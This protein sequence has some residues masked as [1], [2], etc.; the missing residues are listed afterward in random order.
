MGYSQEEV[1]LYAELLVEWFR[2]HARDLP[3]REGYAPYWVLVS[4]FMLQQTQVATVIPYFERW[5]ARWPNLADLAAADEAEVLKAWEGLGYYS[6][7]RNLLRAVRAMT[8]A[9]YSEPPASAVELRAFPGIGEYTAGAVAS[10]GYD[11]PVPA[12]DG[13]AERV[14]SRF[15]GIAEPAGSTALRREVAS[16]VSSMLRHVSARELNQALMDLGAAVCTPRG[17]DCGACPWRE[18][19]VTREEGRVEEFPLPRPRASVSREAAWGLLA[20]RSSSVLLHRRP[21]K[22]LWSSMWETPWFERRSEDFWDDFEAWRA[23]LGVDLE[24]RQDTLTEAGAVSFSFTTHRVRAWVVACEA[25]HAARL[26]D[27]WRFASIGDLDALSLP[28]PSRK[29]LA[30]AKVKKTSM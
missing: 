25:E 19:C 1:R 14:I 12:V 15:F 21:D 16:V 23:S 3:W 10:I 17:A 27:G 6:R 5:I 13:N 22:G 4:E 18:R 29:F 9:G 24:L 28:A 8:E 26:G 30:L 2:A 7:C 20:L 11:L